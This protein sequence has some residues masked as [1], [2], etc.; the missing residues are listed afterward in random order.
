MLECQR[1]PSCSDFHVGGSYGA[2]GRTKSPCLKKKPALFFGQGPAPFGTAR[3]AAQR[4][5]NQ[6]PL[7]LLE[8]CQL[9]AGG[10]RLLAR[11]QLSEAFLGFLEGCFLL[12]L[13]CKIEK[14]VN[15]RGKHF[16]SVKH[17]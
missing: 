2:V 8:H 17:Y 10:S 14:P 15:E 12:R 9:E 6:E 5:L 11:P 7:W 16:L 1:G 4:E 3:L 13:F